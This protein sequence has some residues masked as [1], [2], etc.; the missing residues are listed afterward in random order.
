MNYLQVD[1]LTKSFGERV[2]FENINFGLQQ[3]QKTALVAKN[4]AGKSTLLRILMKKEVPDS[5]EV[6]FR[7]DCVVAYLDQH[8][9]F[10]PEQTIEEAVFAW[11]DPRLEAIRQYEFLLENNPE[12][13]TLQDVIRLVDDL[14]AWDMEAKV[15]EI[16]G[17]LNIHH[18]QQKMGELSGGQRKRV[19]L[20]ALLIREPDLVLLDEPTNHLDVEMIEWLEGYLRQSNLTLLMVT[21]DRYFLDNVCNDILEIDRKNVLRYKGNYAYYLEKKSAALEMF[22]SEVEKARNT[23]TKELEWMRRMPKARGTKAKSRIDSFYEVK[24]KASQRIQDDKVELSVKMNR[25]G[26]KILELIKVSKGFGDRTLIQPF[27]YTFIKG[28]KIGIVGKNGC[29]KS[30]LLKLIMGQ[31]ETDSGKIQVGETVIFGYYSQE[32][33]NLAEDKRVIEIVKDVAEVIPLANGTNLSASQFL[34][35]FL[36]PPEM[37]YTFVSKLSGGEKRRLYL[38]TVLMKNPNFLILDEPTN[39]LDIQTLNILQDFLE[40]F[41]GCVLIV[42]HDRF[43]MDNLAD[44]LFIFEGDGVI[45]DYNGNY[46][47]YRQELSQKEKA[48]KVIAPVVVSEVVQ[49][50]KEKSKPSFKEVHEHQQLEKEIPQLETQLAELTEKL[51]SGIS[52]HVELQKIAQKIAY[53]SNQIEEKSFRW[54][55]LSEI[56]E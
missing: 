31:L 22:N 53:V 6:V 12:S 5:G 11:N 20:A 29:G 21:H 35:L 41:G 36:F 52:D 32:G 3:G 56:I 8:P 10:N 37:Q 1:R 48:P 30:T 40:N 17:K 38:L 28:E 42:S 26:G 47:D 7:N 39:D 18:L 24:E 46:T 2:L 27:T 4:G 14:K 45:R 19:A 33:M 23:F 44:H 49:P 25:L 9:P 54:L 51:N 43:F 15:K 34:Q 55:E 16:L 13:D 50:K